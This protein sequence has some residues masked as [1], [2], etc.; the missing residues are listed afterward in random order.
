MTFDKFKSSLQHLLPHHCLSRLIAKLG[1]SRLIPLKNFLIKIF[2]KHYQVD[3]NIAALT[4]LSD[5]PTFNAFFTRAL[6][7]TARPIVQGV[8]V[9][10]SPAD[11]TV[12]QF[13]SIENSRLI[14]AKGR[15]FDLNDLVGDPHR[16]Q[17]YVNGEFITIYLAPK[18]YHRVHMPLSG[19]L[20]QTIYIPGA[21]FSVNNQ[22]V[23]HTPN[24]FSRNERLVCLFETEVGEMALILVGAM[25]VAGIET[26]WGQCETPCE[27]RQVIVKDY[28]DQNHCLMKGDEM[29]RFQFGSTV[30]VLWG[31]GR[32]QFANIELQQA[33]K[34]GERIGDVIPREEVRNDSD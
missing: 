5:Y 1:N 31:A 29:G 3:I 33:V 11:G 13:G 12:S 20:L 28:R 7:A 32:I 27:D 19:K 4:K 22:S 2:I 17:P 34:M 15:Y 26:V 8:G 18:D 9:I 21:L 10:T 16:A 6:S 24:L 25:L 30:I 23:Q 14:Q